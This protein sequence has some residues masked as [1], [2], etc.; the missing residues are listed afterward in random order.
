MRKK[1]FYAILSATL[2]LAVG[3][4]SIQAATR[5]DLVSGQYSGYG[6][7]TISSKSASARTYV[8]PLASAYVQADYYYIANYETT[9]RTMQ[10]TNSIGNYG[11]AEVYFSVS[12]TDIS[13]YIKAQHSFTS[14][15][16]NNASGRTENHY[17]R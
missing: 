2:L 12:D 4:E 9:P 3:T 1:L 15:S 5:I 11:L 14:S 7:T 8:N 17:I 6:E 13:D 16:G 10:R